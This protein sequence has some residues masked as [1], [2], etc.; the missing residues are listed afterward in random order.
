MFETDKHDQYFLATFKIYEAFINE[1][2][3]LKKNGKERD[4]ETKNVIETKW[5][6]RSTEKTYQMFFLCCHK[7]SDQ[8][9]A[10]LCLCYE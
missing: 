10:V 7:S 8:Q 6:S 9:F 4:A 2:A 1:D 5:K 3:Y